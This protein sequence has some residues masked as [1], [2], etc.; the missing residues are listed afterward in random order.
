MLT[1]DLTCSW[2]KCLSITGVVERRLRYH[3]MICSDGAKVDC[4]ECGKTFPCKSRMKEHISSTHTFIPCQH[5]GKEVKKGKLTQH[6]LQH[7]TADADMPHHCPVCQK[8]F[9]T[10]YKFQD[11]MNIHTGERPHKCK[12]CTKTFANH[13]NMCKHIRESHVEEYHRNKALKQNK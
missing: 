12:Y 6:I 11:H 2:F 3:R 8:G 7:H 10:K 4:P 13:A 5:C 9:T 1:L